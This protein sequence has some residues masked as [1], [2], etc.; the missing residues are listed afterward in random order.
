MSQQDMLRLAQP[1]AVDLAEEL[2]IESEE[3]KMLSNGL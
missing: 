2:A 1:E 3:V